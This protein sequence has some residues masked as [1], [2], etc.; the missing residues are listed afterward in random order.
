[1]FED[2]AITAWTLREITCSATVSGTENQC[3]QGWPIRTFDTPV[4]VVGKRFEG[5]FDGLVLTGKF[6]SATQASGTWTFLPD[7]CC[8]SS[9]TWTASFV[10][11]P[12]P[13]PTGNETGAT[14]EGTTD[15][16]TGGTT[17]TGTGGSTGETTGGTTSIGS[18]G[19]SEALPAPVAGV[20]FAVP[21]DA[22]NYQI[23]ALT[24]TNWYRRNVALPLVENVAAIN[25]AAQAH[26]DYY[27]LHKADYSAGKV[28]GGAHSESPAI[29]AGFTGESFG[30]RMATAGY[31]GQPGF[32]VM[33][34]I[35]NATA[36]VDGW[37]ATV[38][39]R[40]PFMSPDMVHAGAGGAPGVD[41]MDFGVQ[42][43]SDK[44]RVVVYPWPDQTGVPTSWNGAE[45]PQPPK[46]DN[47]YP[48][49]PIITLHTSQGAPLEIDTHK[50][51]DSAGNEVA[52]VWHPK[53][54]NG[55]MSAT[56]AMYSHDPL[57]SSA[58][59]TVIVEGE[60]GGSSWYKEWKFTTK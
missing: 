43:S 28:P 58:Q 33:G 21:D 23:A 36:A 48:S 32:E 20:D 53:G 50:L 34:F 9:G 4:D 24:R 13:L 15:I 38:Y 37:V 42:N 52:H 55:F 17:A 47:G 2:G 51:L 41:V 18:G 11:P 44:E 54:S 39:H 22:T 35:F 26:A 46:P 12:D 7:K 56:W 10:A 5:N 40:I 49:G 45:S 59:F 30:E 6:T 19:G 16:G 14:T 25:H 60:L 1:M 8:T 31:T 27:S 29:S 57:P 3:N